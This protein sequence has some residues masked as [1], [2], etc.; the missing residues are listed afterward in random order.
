MSIKFNNE[1]ISMFTRCV[2]RN[3]GKFAN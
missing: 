3:T 2:L 1:M